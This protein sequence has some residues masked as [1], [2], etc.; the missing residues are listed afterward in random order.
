MKRHRWTRAARAAATDVP[1]AT[2]RAPKAKQRPYWYLHD[3]MRQ[4]E[5]DI[6]RLRRELEQELWL[7]EQL[8]KRLREKEPAALAA[9]DAG[10]ALPSPPV[11]D[12]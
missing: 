7:H 8:K 3:T 11:N 6:A 9:W 4:V 12:G 5:S 1:P 10:K 2:R